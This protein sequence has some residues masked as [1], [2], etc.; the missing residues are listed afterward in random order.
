MKMG[1]YPL[2][3]DKDLK[4]VSGMIYRRGKKDRS[5]FGIT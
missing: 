4:M 3:L 5:Y 1:K 2:L